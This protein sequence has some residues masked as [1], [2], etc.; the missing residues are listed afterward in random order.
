[1]PETPPTTAP[2]TILRLLNWTREHFESRGLDEPRL[3]AELLLAKVLGCK[4]I[5]L[6]A[7]FEQSPTN[8]QRAALRELVKAAAEHKPI[9]YL[10]G[11]KEFYSLEFAVTPDVLIPRPETETLV[12]RALALCKS[13]D[14][15]RIEIADIG[16][17]SGCIAI[18]IAR[19]ELRAFV[20]AVDVSEAALDVASA[21]AAKHGITD[22]V[23][24][25]KAD[26]LDLPPEV[27]PANGFSMIVSNPPYVGLS[28]CESLPANVRE[29]E[30][31]TALFA[32]P[33]G[34]DIY[35]RLARQIPAALAPGGRLLLEIGMNQAD[36]VTTLF[37]QVGLKASGSFKDMRGITRVLAFESEPQS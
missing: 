34:L 4:R 6:Y 9:A 28:E 8:E 12:D 15:A 7:R 10:I 37:E 5:D 35:Q 29:Y 22:R 14:A 18:A 11:H 20:T 21:N 27:R 31:A 13:I 2:W 30:P 24:F 25:V 23:R 32:G 26:L 16:T 1:M 3:S 33:D 17:G 19:R 36:P